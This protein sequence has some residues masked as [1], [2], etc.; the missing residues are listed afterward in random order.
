VATQLQPAGDTFS[1][2]AFG[3]RASDGKFVIYHSVDN[4]IYQSVDKGAFAQITASVS[5]L[6]YSQDYNYDFV[7]LFLIPQT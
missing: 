6:A 5:A 2:W 4:K 1:N 3:N 7:R